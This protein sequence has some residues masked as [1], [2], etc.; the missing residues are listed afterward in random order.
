MAGVEPIDLV[1]NDTLS[2]DGFSRP[3]VI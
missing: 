1:L 3:G 2:L